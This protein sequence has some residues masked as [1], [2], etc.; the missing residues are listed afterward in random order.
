MA[1]HREKQFLESTSSISDHANFGLLL[2]K[3]S[4]YA[5]S[6]GQENDTGSIVIDGV[7]EF[8]VTDVQVYKGYVLHVG[9][10]KYG[11]LKVGDEVVSSYDEVRQF[12]CPNEYTA[13]NLHDYSSVVGR[14]ETITLL[15]ISSIFPCVKFSG[16]I[17]IRRVPSSRPLSCALTFLIKLRSKRQSW[18]G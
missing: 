9:K 8:E 12:S 10:M 4:F 5:E 17:L 2:D 1:I 18:S 11:E 3:T 15:P 7:A 16:T 13:D 6:G 14:F